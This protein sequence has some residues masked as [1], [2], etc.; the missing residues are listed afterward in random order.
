MLGSFATSTLLTKNSFLD[1]IRK[2]YVQ[3]ARMK[4]LSER[5]VL[6]GHVFRNAMLIVI[7]GFPGAFVGA[8]FTG[9]LLIEQV[10]S[11]D[12][13]GYLSYNSL[14]QRD[15]PVV[16]GNLYVFALIGLSSICSPTSPTP[17]SIRASISKAGSCDERAWLRLTPLNRRRL[18]RTSGATG[19]ATGRSG[20]FCVLFVVSLFAE[21]V[22]N[23]RPLIASYKGELLF[24]VFVDYPEDKF[25]GF[26]ATTDYRDPTIADEIKAHG[27]MIWPPIRFANNTVKLDPPTPFPSPPTWWLSEAQCKTAIAAEVGAR[28]HQ[29]AARRRIAAA[30]SSRNGSAPTPTATTSSRG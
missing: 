11:L 13:L 12:G 4:G 9:S 16:L 5:R 7:A 24:P 19:A 25:G 18:G 21:F 27:W 6:Y 10:F 3:T 20:S 28:R 23:D 2:A 22:A 8:F 14:I 26:E 17:G 29:A 1:E 15:Y 30:I